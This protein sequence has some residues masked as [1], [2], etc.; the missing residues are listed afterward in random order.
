MKLII[1]YIISNHDRSMIFVLF[2]AQKKTFW[3]TTCW[4]RKMFG[5]LVYIWNQSSQRLSKS[6]VD[7]FYIGNKHCSRTI[8]IIYRELRKPIC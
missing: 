4:Y 8:Y 2:V 6:T 1:G 5:G 3:V 7:F